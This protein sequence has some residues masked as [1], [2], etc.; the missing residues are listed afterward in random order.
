MHP[1]WYMAVE[2]IRGD[3]MS[4]ATLQSPFMKQASTTCILHFFY[5]MYGEGMFIGSMSSANK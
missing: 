2:P 4:P 1:G 3:Q 5:N